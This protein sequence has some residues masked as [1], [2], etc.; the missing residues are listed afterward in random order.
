MLDQE[1]V[2]RST[3]LHLYQHE[4]ACQLRTVEYKLQFAFCQLPLN[5]RCLAALDLG[6]ELLG[7]TYIRLPPPVV[8][9]QDRTGPILTFR[10]H[11]LESSVLQRMIFHLDGQVLV[12]GIQGGPL[13]DSPASEHPVN[14]KPQ[15]IV[16]RR[17]R[18]L[19]HAE[20]GPAPGRSLLAPNGFG[21]ERKITFGPISFESVSG[22]GFIAA[23]LLHAVFPSGGWCI[24]HSR[25]PPG[26]VSLRGRIWR[27]GDLRWKPARS[28]YLLLVVRIGC[29]IQQY[30]G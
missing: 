22:N 16:K 15:I 20:D 11:S 23:G 3:P 13:G 18:M 26:F 30:P 24:C 10:Y 28:V 17:S 6:S 1:P 12:G 7:P 29:R 27:L 4:A 5:I 9:E 21:C 8:P 25:Y 2:F 19:L 14:F